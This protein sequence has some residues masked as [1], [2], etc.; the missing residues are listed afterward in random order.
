MRVYKSFLIVMGILSLILLSYTLV[1]AVEST[2]HGQFRINYYNLSQDDE[3]C[4]AAAEAAETCSDASVAAAR[5]RWR[6]TWDATISEDVSM[7]LQLN[8]G[9]ITSNTANARYEQGDDPAVALRHAMLLFTVP[10]VGGK[11]AAGLVPVSDK[12]GDT[13]FSGDWDFNPLTLAYMGKVGVADI[14]LATAK[15]ME[16]GEAFTDPGTRDDLDV[17]L[18]DVDAPVGNG[19][20]GGSVYALVSQAGFAALGGDKGSQYYYGLRAAQDVGPVKVK[21][22]ILG[23]S[24]TSENVAGQDVDNSGFAGKLEGIMALG[25]AHVGLM[26]ITA[27]GDK[28]F[29]TTDDADS[30]ITPMTLIGHTGYWGYTG[31]L[32]IQGPTDT[33]IDSPV[34]IDG[35]RYDNGSG[36]G[37]GITTVQIKAD[38]PIMERLTGYVAVGIF[39]SAEVPNGFDEAIG[40]DFYAQGKYNIAENLNLEAGVDVALLDKDNPVYGYADDNTI[41][42]GFARLQLE[43]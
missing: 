36:L 26:F 39:Q 27:S 40:T 17:H 2:F 7:H 9:H 11:I 18:V 33:G 5:L 1:S 14:R 8:I 12:F 31:K 42:V 41:T 28:E 4:S 3:A 22:F 38:F 15:L 35:A 6:P 30:F 19:T 29:G 13:L 32:N 37:S 10:G 43:Y 23:N 25:P 20:V 24:G 21:V 34:N 16:N